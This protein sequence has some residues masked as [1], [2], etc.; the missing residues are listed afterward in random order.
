MLVPYM[1]L[2][3]GISNLFAREV[4]EHLETNVWLAEKM[5]NVR[6]NIQKVNNLFRIEKS[7]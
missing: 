2:A 7:S 3:E 4:S 6:F 1:A 5:L